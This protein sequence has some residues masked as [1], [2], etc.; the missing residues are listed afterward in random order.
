MW[1]RFLRRK[2]APS[3]LFYDSEHGWQDED[4]PIYSDWHY[5]AWMLGMLGAIALLGFVLG[6][7]AFI[8]TFLIIKGRARWY[9]AALAASGTI[10]LFAFL[11]Y[12]L[13]LEYPAGILQ[14]LLPMPWP[15]D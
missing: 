13:G 5:Q 12:M 1:V 8:T 15:F 11:S 10:V 4:K 3:Y 7:Y 14:W 2:K 9:K 6:I